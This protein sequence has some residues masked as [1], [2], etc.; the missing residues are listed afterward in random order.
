MV[1]F[2]LKWGRLHIWLAPHQK[3]LAPPLKWHLLYIGASPLQ[4]S[5]PFSEGFLLF[6]QTPHQNGGF[7]FGRGFF[8]EGFGITLN[9]DHL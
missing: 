2:S 9:L 7:K 1:R 8:S 5:A 6:M 3:W 4:Y